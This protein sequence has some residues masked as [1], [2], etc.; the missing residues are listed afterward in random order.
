MCLRTTGRIVEIRDEPSGARMA[1]DYTTAHAGFARTKIEEASAMTTIVT[2][3][4]YG[5]FGDTAPIPA[6][7][8]SR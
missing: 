3:T 6:G 4:E 2:M 1:H 5:V 7:G 8:G